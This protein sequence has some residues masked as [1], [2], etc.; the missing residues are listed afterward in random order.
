M[1]FL[2]LILGFVL[3]IGLVVVHEYGHFIAA[4]RS[5]VEVEE[6]GIGFPPK[7]WVKKLKSGLLFSINWLPLGGFVRLK[8]ENESDKRPGS[9]GAARLRHKIIIMLAGVIMNLLTAFILFTIAAWTGM[10]QLLDNQ[11]SVASDAR[12]IRRDVLVG[13]VLANSPAENSGLKQKD[14]LLTIGIPD[15][16]RRTIISA[17]NLSNITSEFA[18]QKVEITY[19]RSG[20]VKKTSVTLR[21]NEEV[22]KSRSTPEPKGYLGVVPGE[23]TLIRSTWSAPIVAAGL[24]KQFTVENVKSIG[25]ALTNIFRGNGSAASEQIAGPVGVVRLIFD[26]STLGVQAILL[27]MGY[28]SLTLALMNALPIPALDGGRLFVTLLFRAIKKPLKKETEELIHGTGFIVLVSFV[29]LVSIID[30]KRLF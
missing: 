14:V 9:F 8:G 3:F 19:R 2:L 4:R 24:V 21:T 7:A 16:Y 23:Y 20:E 13:D 12:T 28:I 10:P 22:D 26:G 11:F 17:E 18:G 29:L 15:S 1:T 5:G 30:V 25:S 6:F 27:I